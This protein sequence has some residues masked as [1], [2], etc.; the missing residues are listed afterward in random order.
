MTWED[1]L[2][3]VSSV[4]L[5]IAAT[6]EL[7]CQRQVNRACLAAETPAVYPAV[8]V[9]DRVRPAEVGEVL[10]VL[11]GR[12]TPC[13]E[14]AVTFRQ[15]SL[16]AQAARGAMLDIQQVAL[17]TAHVVGALLDPA[18]ENSAILDPRRTLIYLHGF[19]PTSP[20]IRASFP[21]DGLFS[22]Y[23]EVPFPQEPCPACG[24]QTEDPRLRVLPGAAPPM[25]PGTR[26]RQPE[27]VAPPR[28]APQPTGPPTWLL[29]LVGLV[30]A[31]A[32][33][34]LLSWGI[35]A[36]VGAVASWVHSLTGSTHAAATGNAP[37]HRPPAGRHVAAPLPA[38]PSRSPSPSNSPQSVPP[39]TSP[40]SFALT[41]PHDMTTA[42]VQQYDDSGASAQLT[43]TAVPSYD[44][45]CV[46]GG[47]DLGG[48]DLDSFCSWLAQQDHYQSPDGW[49][50]GNPERFDTNTSDQ[51]WLDWR[52]YNTENRP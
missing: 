13:Y 10:W 3:W 22:R 7:D 17:A 41:Y 44:V 48:L 34:A 21:V 26:P 11:P 37:A 43:S 52:C 23:I 24:G 14:C 8:W 45:V 36:G 20:R 18:N 15:G 4:D 38:A 35:R 6:D 47:A 46:Q 40:A 12:H 27:V 50:S 25:P 32:A 29:P 51:P 16:D 33:L 1:Q 9:D 5:V 49:W 31:L 30:A 2:R 42:C 39:W 19:T 28:Q